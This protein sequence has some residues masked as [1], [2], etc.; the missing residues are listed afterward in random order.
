MTSLRLPGL[1]ALLLLI[2]ITADFMDPL[3]PG[4]FSV[5]DDG[6]F[7]DGIVQLRSNASANL[8]P[9]A[10]LMPSAARADR[11]GNA[12]A[13]VRT[14]ARPLRPKPVRWK[15]LKHDDSASFASS[16]P[17]DS[18]PTPPQS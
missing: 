2:Y 13:K 11:H 7:V 14:V 17:S 18:S 5:E 8:T 15:S 6:L 16:S 4:A 12:A 10:S 1:L 3:T 9:P